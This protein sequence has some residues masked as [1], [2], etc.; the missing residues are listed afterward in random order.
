M[1]KRFTGIERASST[2]DIY[3]ISTYPPRNCGIATFTSDLSHAVGEE[4]GNEHIHIVAINNRA[5]GYD[6]PEEV[7]FEISQNQIHDYRLAAEYINLSNAKVVSVQHEFGIFGGEKGIYITHLLANLKKPVVT[8]LHTV[9][10]NPEDEYK[11]VLI[12]VAKLS[13]R[14]SYEP[15]S[16]GYSTRRI[17]YTK[18]KDSFYTSWRARCCFC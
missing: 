10:K 15:S 7:S 9:L 8:T 6:Y 3:F 11:R 17:W 14:L 13:Q 5:E 12:E 18:G 1:A 4:L 2:G 16:R